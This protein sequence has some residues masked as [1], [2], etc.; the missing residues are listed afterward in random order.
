MSC[1]QWV[2]SAKCKILYLIAITWESS[3]CRESMSY[4]HTPI[5]WVGWEN[6][7]LSQNVAFVVN[8]GWVKYEISNDFGFK[9]VIFVFKLFLVSKVL[10][11]V[12][13]CLYLQFN[14]KMVINEAATH[15]I[16]CAT[17]E[18][19]LCNSIPVI[20]IIRV[21]FQSCERAVYLCLYLAPCTL[22]LTLY[23]LA[24]HVCY[25]HGYHVQKLHWFYLISWLQSLWWTHQ[26]A[27]C[28][29]FS[30]L[31]QFGM[32]LYLWEMEFTKMACLNLP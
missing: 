29:L 10:F 9:S 20:G 19:K 8:Y 14:R 25:E 3:G 6:Y 1:M 32:E 4:H 22:C 23:Q 5:P 21:S 15:W 17:I 7:L 24:S 13:S 2:N 28:L 18:Q 12:S 16:A 11:I 26:L 30:S 27:W 31:W